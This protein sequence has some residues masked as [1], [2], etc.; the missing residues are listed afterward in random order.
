MNW[1][2]GTHYANGVVVDPLKGGTQREVTGLLEER[3]VVLMEP[4]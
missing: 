2:Y 3:Y 1:K 4:G